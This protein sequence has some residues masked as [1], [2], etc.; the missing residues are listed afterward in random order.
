VLRRLC[1]VSAAL[2]HAHS[3]LRHSRLRTQTCAHSRLRHSRLRTFACIGILSDRVP[4]AP[5]LTSAA[6]LAA[7]L[8]HCGRSQARARARSDVADAMA[9]Q[10]QSRARRQGRLEGCY[11]GAQ[12]VL[13]G[14]S[15]GTQ[16]VLKGYL[17]FVVGLLIVARGNYRINQGTHGTHGT[18][19]TQWRVAPAMGQASYLHFAAPLGRR[20]PGTATVGSDPAPPC[21]YQEESPLK[22]APLY[23]APLP[24]ASTGMRG[25]AVQRRPAQGRRSSRCRSALG[26]S[27]SGPRRCGCVARARRRVWTHHWQ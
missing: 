27:G 21:G 12:G 17:R 20:K 1:A 9:R 2:L 7:V 6:A 25:Y 5:Q 19:G 4:M 3:R 16:G 24:P 11:R 18:H 22:A 14:Y 10:Q 23:R 13:K 26:R 8:W 15:R